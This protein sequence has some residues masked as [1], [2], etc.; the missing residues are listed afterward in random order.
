MLN[1]T[2]TT[3]WFALP[4]ANRMRFARKFAVSTQTATLEAIIT[5]GE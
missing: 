1:D 5:W 4:Q 2:S 3:P